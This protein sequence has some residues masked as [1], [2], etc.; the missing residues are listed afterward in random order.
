MGQGHP[1]IASLLVQAR[2]A[3]GISQRELSMRSGLTQAQISRIENGLVDMR[4]SSLLA[5]ANQLNLEFRFEQLSLSDSSSEK[6]KSPQAGG[7]SIARSSQPMPDPAPRIGI[8]G[9]IEE[10][11]L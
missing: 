9:D 4:F 6:P 8:F 11:L 7:P 1:G 3:L 2:R 10:E 5:L